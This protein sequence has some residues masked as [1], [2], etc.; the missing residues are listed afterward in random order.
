ML[1]Q[2]RLEHVS[3]KI[4]LVVAHP[5]MHIR[6]RVELACDIVERED[7]AAAGHGADGPVAVLQLA[8]DH[9]AVPHDPADRLDYQTIGS[10]FLQQRAELVASA[11]PLA[12]GTDAGPRQVDAVGLW[13]WKSKL[14]EVQVKEPLVV[15]HALPAVVVEDET[16]PVADAVDAEEIQH[17]GIVA[18]APAE[19][20]ELIFGPR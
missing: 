17:V 14:C 11:E 19:A 12:R 20:I 2:P 3:G 7:L 13:H 15:E 4:Q 6:R 5:I 16:E 9:D 18:V 1:L 8:Q 10:Q